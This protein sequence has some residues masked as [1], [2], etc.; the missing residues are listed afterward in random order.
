MIEVIVDQRPLS[1]TPLKGGGLSEWERAH[2]SRV[3]GFH[4]QLLIYLFVQYAHFAPW[5]TLCNAPNW[6]T[7]L[8][9]N[10]SSCNTFA[11]LKNM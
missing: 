4:E 3:V 10:F 7:S 8:S 6:R 1:P 5:R 2:D 9:T 11:R